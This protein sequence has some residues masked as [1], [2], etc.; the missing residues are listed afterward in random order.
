MKSKWAPYLS[1]AAILLYWTIFSARQVL[2]AEERSFPTD[3]RAIFLQ[4]CIKAVVVLVVIWLLLRSSGESLADLGFSRQA[5]R[6]IWRNGVL[7]SIPVFIVMNAV[8]NS[9]LGMLMHAGTTPVLKTLFHDP[10]QAPYWIFTAIVGGGFVEELQR[11]FT[12]TRIERLFGRSGLIA[13]ILVDS[14]VFGLGHVTREPP[15]RSPRLSRE[16]CSP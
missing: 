10:R 2:Q 5:C 11:A 13:A 1:L 15:A 3:V 8:L 12:L 6:G 16:W 14:V 7:P 4:V 9:I